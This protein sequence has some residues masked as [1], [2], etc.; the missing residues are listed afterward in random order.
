MA[1]AEQA[2][3]P[4]GKPRYVNRFAGNGF[5]CP[6]AQKGKDFLTVRKDCRKPPVTLAQRTAMQSGSARPGSHAAASQE[7]CVH[8]FFVDRDAQ[9]AKIARDLPPARLAPGAC[10]VCA[11]S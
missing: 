4:G 10:S 5:S 7:C 1:G 9:T 11:T 2:N 3:R 6:S 8:V